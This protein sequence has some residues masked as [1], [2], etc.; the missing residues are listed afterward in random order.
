MK[1]ICASARIARIK[2]YFI[3]SILNHWNISY[4]MHIENNTFNSIEE[5]FKIK[6]NKLINIVCSNNLC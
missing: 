3:N 2:K 5:L 1:P 4:K 6:K